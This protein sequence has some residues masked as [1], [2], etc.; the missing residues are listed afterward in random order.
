MNKLSVKLVLAA[1]GAVLLVVAVVFLTRPV[2][3]VAIVKRDKAVNAKPGSVTVMAEYQMEL[4]SEVGGRL[5]RSE[6]DP[7]KLVRQ[8]DFLAQ[9]DTG[10]LQLE[11][12]HVQSEY[13]AA[14]QRIAIGSQIALDLATAR[15]NLENFER[16]TKSGNYPEADL[17]KQRRLVE[18]IRQKHELE[19]LANR[20]AAEGFENTLKVKKRQLEKMTITAPFDGVVSEVLAR[21]GDIIGFNTPVAILISTSRT[22]EAKISEEDFADIRVGQKASVRFLTYGESSV[23]AS[24]VKILPTADAATQRYLVHL[25]VDIAPEKLVPGITGEVSIDVGEHEK[26]LIVPRRAVQGHS[27]YA[28][29]NGRVELRK[30]ELGYVS[31]NEVEVLSGVKEGEQ[32]IVEQLDRFQPGDHVR[33]VVEK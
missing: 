19:Q 6:L 14:K 22:V 18:Q 23:S 20:Q 10:D 5:I 28:V 26:T 1:V 3:Q 4:K 13:E 12:E 7:G 27:L 30:V 24:V 11:V 29:I 33:P 31:L 8:G 15:D 16:L 25:R 21:P 2:A 17:V 32:V 9:I